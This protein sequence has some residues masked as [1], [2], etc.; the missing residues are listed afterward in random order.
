LV[1]DKTFRGGGRI[2]IRNIEPLGTS[3]SGG[4]T[5]LFV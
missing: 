5:G 2:G 3:L 1:K 4:H